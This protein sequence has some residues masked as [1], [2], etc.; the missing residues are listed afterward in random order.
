[1]IMTFITDLVAEHEIQM[2][3][4]LVR[5]FPLTTGQWVSEEQW[6]VGFGF[7]LC[8]FEDTIYIWGGRQIQLDGAF[9]CLP[10]CYVYTL[11]LTTLEWKTLE[12]TGDDPP[13]CHWSSCAQIENLVYIFGGLDKDSEANN[14]ILT[15]EPKVAR[16]EKNEVSGYRPNPRFGHQGWSFRGKVFFFG[17]KQRSLPTAEHGSFDNGVYQFDPESRSWSQ[18]ETK[19]VQ[20]KPRYLHTAER[21]QDQVF[22]HGGFSSAGILNET[23]VLDLVSMTWTLLSTNGPKLYGHSLVAT[24]RPPLNL[25]L[26][27]GSPTYGGAT[28]ISKWVWLF[29][30]VGN[31]WKKT[32]ALPHHMVGQY[33]GLRNH[34]S[35]VMVHN[36]EMFIVTLGG[37]KDAAKRRH[38]E[39]ILIY[40][41]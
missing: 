11:N 8:K 7:S 41:V 19:G 4:R 38:P 3:E 5:L 37:F 24:V 16:F 2:E 12:A 33:G 28:C 26:I 31:T 15:F 23:L 30:A 25:F 6:P 9:Q 40:K 10:R 18:V 27:G 32:R 17:G 34:H 13:H 22:V 35:I 29:D 1:M 21:V 14:N 20:P 36:E 39:H